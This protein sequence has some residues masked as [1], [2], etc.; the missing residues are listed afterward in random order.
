MHKRAIIT[1]SHVERSTDTVDVEFKL[2]DHSYAQ[3]WA[4]CIKSVQ[5]APNDFGFPRRLEED[6]EIYQARIQ[7]QLDLIPELE[8]TVIDQDAVNTI[9]RY[10]EDNH[11]QADKLLTLHNDIHYLESLWEGAREVVFKKLQWVPPGIRIPMEPEDYKCYTTQPCEN[12][13][14]ADF[15]HVGRTPHNT[16]YYK[17]DTSLSTSCRIQEDVTSGC[18]WWFKDNSHIYEDRKGFVEWFY[19]NR[20]YFSRKYGIS[21]PHDP[22]M[23]YGRVILA[24]AD[25]L[26]G[27]EWDFV[28]QLIVE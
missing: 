19:D 7:A 14:E 16:W 11:E 28:Q 24:T 23:C 25:E 3:K 2:N 10:I 27:P 17:D 21:W 4:E 8:F 20:S 26:P 1:L 15:S 9:H 22:R 6:P 12:Y 5:G 18:M 13:L